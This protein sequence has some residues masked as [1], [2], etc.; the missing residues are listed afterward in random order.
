MPPFAFNGIIS[1]QGRED[2]F[3]FNASKDMALDVNVFARRLRS[4][5]DS[6]IEI[7]DPVG[8]SL[9]SNDDAAGADSSLKFTPAATTNYFL[10]IRDT[11]RHGGPDFVYR[12]EIAPVQPHLEIKIPEVS[13]ND[14]Q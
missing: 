4:H 9:A 7:Y 12:V 11:L 3:R 6:V 2:W 14:T 8:K 1:E 10:R 13:R 5:L